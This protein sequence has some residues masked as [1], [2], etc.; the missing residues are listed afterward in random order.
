MLEFSSSF[1]S[2]HVTHWY[3]KHPYI[4]IYI[5]IY[6]YIYIIILIYFIY[7]FIIFLW[8]RFPRLEKPGF[9]CGSL[10][11]IDL[12]IYKCHAHLYSKHIFHYQA[13]KFWVKT[14]TKHIYACPVNRKQVKRSDSLAKKRGNPEEHSF[15]KISYIENF[16]LQHMN[17]MSLLY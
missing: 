1:S 12:E 13:L 4:H 3:V 15:L 2:H 5:Y 9:F 7:L 17:Q 6:I 16:T 14:V 10:S 11:V 8:S